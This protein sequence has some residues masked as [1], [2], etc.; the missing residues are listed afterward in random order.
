MGQKFLV[1]AG[2]MLLKVV[3]ATLSERFS[4]LRQRAQCNGL[5]RGLHGCA[6]PSRYMSRVL[7]YS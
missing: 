4:V 3:G 2:I 7:S 6:L 1:T 5:P